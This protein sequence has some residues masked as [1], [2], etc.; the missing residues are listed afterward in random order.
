MNLAYL[1][2]KQKRLHWKIQAS[3]HKYRQRAEND[4]RTAPRL[5]SGSGRYAHTRAGKD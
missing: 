3:A 5:L 4:T 2:R 1:G